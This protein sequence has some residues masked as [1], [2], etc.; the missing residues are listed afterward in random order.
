MIRIL[1]IRLAPYLLFNVPHPQDVAAPL[2]IGYSISI[3]RKD[4]HDVSFIDTEAEKYSMKKV[5]E[6]IKEINPNIIFIHCMTPTAEVL[7]KLANLIKES[8]IKVLI[9]AMGQHA[10]VLPKTFLFK[11]SPVDLCINGEAELT[12]KELVN[13]HS[14]SKNIYSINSITYFD[15]KN[16]KIH[17]N[18]QRE[19]ISNLDELPFPAHDLFMKDSYKIYYPIRLYKKVKWG[20]MLSSRG[21]PYSCIFCSPTL[22][23][24]YGKNYRIRSAKNVVDEMEFLVSKGVNAIDFIDDTFTFDQKRTMEICDELIKRKINVKWIA[25]TRVDHV[26]MELLK[27]M[28]KAGCS[29]L[30]FGI[31]SGVERILKILKKGETVGQMKKA[32]KLTKK[33]GILTVAYFMLGSPTETEEEVKKTF[34]LCK[35]LKPDL[36]QVAYFT[37]YP[38]SE[39]YEKMSDQ[40]KLKFDT[41]SH[42]NEIGYNFSNIPTRKLRK[43]QR[44]FYKRY[45]FSPLFL[46]KYLTKRLL[47]MIFNFKSEYNLL[48]SGIDFLFKKPK[49]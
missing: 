26:S 5:L 20:F 37:P 21:C 28:R 12:I 18:K 36:L 46:S 44:R 19:L 22:R 11:D 4:N 6:E 23:I 14:K 3:L 31:E 30:C 29:T 39:A 41:L 25:Q 45:F 38:G 35:Q 2:D 16:N 47:F 8:K 49:C 24:S 33:A 7:L 32:F 17:Y 15:K 10:T 9:V 48:S 42:Y 43:M 27:K 13:Y 40:Q 34:K 1:F